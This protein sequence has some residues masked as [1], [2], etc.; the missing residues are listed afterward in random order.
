MHAHNAAAWNVKQLD[1]A[2]ERES[3]KSDV[4]CT[5]KQEVL[6]SISG[7]QSESELHSAHVLTIAIAIR[8]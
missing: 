6:T 1:Q 3:C 7:V 2:S 4:H 5:G 8:Q